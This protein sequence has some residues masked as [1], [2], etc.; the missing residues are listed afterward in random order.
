[1]MPS[2]EHHEIKWQGIKPT[3]VSGFEPLT[4]GEDLWQAK[5]T[6]PGR[7]RLL[8]QPLSF[9][10]GKDKY[11][12]LKM[13]TDSG[14]SVQVA[15]AGDGKYSLI[16]S[17]RS[18]LPAG[19]GPIILQFDLRQF[20]LWKGMVRSLW[21]TLEQTAPGDILQFY[22]ACSA[23]QPVEVGDA[24]QVEAVTAKAEV[25]AMTDRMAAYHHT[26]IDVDETK[27]NTEILTYNLDEVAALG[28]YLLARLV[29]YVEVGGQQL[30]PDL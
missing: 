24:D 13:A 25:W 17:F 10:A 8:I 19:E 9:D 15:F 20:P 30:G 3:V 12:Y 2:K 5:V 6:D 7:A 22:G 18:I 11:L 28:Q 27:P 29:P 26:L 1:M 21:L 23:S 4:E 14:C 16:R